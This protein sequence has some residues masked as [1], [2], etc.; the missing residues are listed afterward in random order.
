MKPGSQPEQA[1]L[2]QCQFVPCACSVDAGNQVFC[3]VN[4]TRALIGPI[5]P[6]DLTLM[7]DQ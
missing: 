7:P 2:N 5:I 3:N 6:R 4:H 1:S